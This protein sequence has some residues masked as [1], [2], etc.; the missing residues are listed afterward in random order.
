MNGGSTDGPSWRSSVQCFLGAGPCGWM[1]LWEGFGLKFF[2]WQDYWDSSI[3]LKNPRD[4]ISHNNR[5]QDDEESDVKQTLVMVASGTIGDQELEDDVSTHSE[6]LRYFPNLFVLVD[7]Y[8]NRLFMKSND[9]S[10]QRIVEEL[11]PASAGLEPFAKTPISWSKVSYYK[12]E[13]VPLLKH[14]KVV[15]FTHRF[16]G[17]GRLKHVGWFGLCCCPSE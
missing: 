14:H 9:F 17:P 11:P 12:M 2:F 4:H 3:S 15:Y 16:S 8:W 1:G 10:L 7:D 13:I 5:Y 6:I